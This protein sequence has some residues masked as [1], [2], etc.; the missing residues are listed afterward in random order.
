MRLGIF[1]VIALVFTLCWWMFASEVL[2][3]ANTAVYF[4][5]PA[6]GNLML[7]WSLSVWRRSAS[8]ARTAAISSLSV[9]VVALAFGIVV[10]V[11]V[12]KSDRPDNYQLVE[13]VPAAQTV[14]PR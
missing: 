2:H 4:L 12:W 13:H 11:A 5:I 7:A 3:T 9:G 6:I 8:I 10:V 1:V 14:L